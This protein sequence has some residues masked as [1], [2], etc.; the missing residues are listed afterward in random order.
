MRRNLAGA[1]AALLM[2]AALV[3]CGGEDGS[4]GSRPSFAP[5]RS[6]TRELPSPTSSE[7]GEPTAPDSSPGLGGHDRTTAEQDSDRAT[8]VHQGHPSPSDRSDEPTSEPAS[9]SAEGSTARTDGEDS[10]GSDDDA[11][12]TWLWW[13]LAVLVL[14]A[15]VAHSAADAGPAPHRLASRALR[16]RG[17]ARLGRPRAPSRTAPR[18]LARAGRRRLGGRSASSR[19]RRRTSSRCSS[20]APPTRR[21][22]NAR[23]HFGTP[24]AWPGADGAARRAG[25]SRHLGPRPGRD[26]GRPRGGTRPAARG[27]RLNRVR[28]AATTPG[29]RPSRP[30]R[31]GTASPTRRRRAGGRRRAPASSPG[32]RRSR[33]STTHGCFLIAPKQRIADSPGLMI[34]VPASTPKTPTLVIVKVP[35]L[36]SAGWVLPSRATA[37][38]SPS[39]VAS[40]TSERSWASLMFGTTRPRGVAAAMPR[41]T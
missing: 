36:I 18:R 9:S 1:V 41:L 4:G 23:G 15:V 37:V 10:T 40:S 35:P 33:R 32:G 13:L 39:A 28:T 5:T 24:P 12:P 16:G 29:P 20:P 8:R 26:H 19:P 7:T 3:A 25:T 31:R 14:G 2:A 27:A 30:R 22:G 17:R 11:T 21:A 34:G 38:S 6:P